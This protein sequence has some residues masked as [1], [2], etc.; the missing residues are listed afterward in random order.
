[1]QDS[2]DNG[3]AGDQVIALDST[4]DSLIFR[5]PSSGGT[6]GT[7]YILTLDQLATDGTG[8]LNIQSAGTGNLLT[9][10]DTTATA[11]DV[12]VVQDGGAVILENQTDSTGA[13]RVRDALGQTQFR[14]D[15]TNASYS[16]VYIGGA[17]GK[18]G[19]RLG[20]Y[21]NGGTSTHAIIASDTGLGGTDGF[22]IYDDVANKH[23]FSLDS[24][25]AVTSRNH[26]DS[27]IAF[28]I[29]NAAGYNY[30]SVDTSNTTHA[31]VN[32]GGNVG[33]PSNSQ[34]NF[35]RAASEG[36]SIIASDNS[37]GGTGGFGIFDDV[38]NAYVLSFSA[39]GSAYFRNQTDSTDA[40]SVQNAAGDDILN[41]DTEHGVITVAASIVPNNS[42]A[43]TPTSLVS[44]ARDTTDNVGQHTAITIGSD[45][46]PVVSYYNVTNTS[47]KV[48]KCGVED[49]SSGNVINEVDNTA[50]VG[51]DTSIAIG[52][53]GFPV[54][55][56][57]DETNGNLRVAK[58]GDVSCTPALVSLN[59]A[60]TGTDLGRESSIAIGTDG[61]PIISH[62]DDN[63]NDLRVTKCDDVACTPAGNTSTA[64]ETSD[65]TGY[66]SSLT[67]GS[68]GL[69]VVAYHN[70]TGGVSLKV[71]KC[72]NTSCTS[73]NT[74][75]EVDVVGGSTL[76]KGA[77]IAIASDGFPV[78]AHQDA[79]ADDM[80]VVKCTNAT[81]TTFNT[82]QIVNSTNAQDPKLVIGT[83]GLPVIA[84]H[85]N[86]SSDLIVTKCGN[87]N[88]TSGNSTTTV[89]TTNDVGQNPSIVI[90]ANGLPVIA[91]YDATAD[92]LR[93]TRCG[94]VSCSG[95]GN[96]VTGG[97]NLGSIPVA[98]ENAYINDISSSNV[99][100]GLTLS[101]NGIERIA[102]G[103][104]GTGTFNLNQ[105]TFNGDILIG[106]KPDFEVP[107]Y[108]VSD[109][110]AGTIDSGGTS[111]IDGIDSMIEYNGSL[112]VGTNEPN[113][114]EIYRYDGNNDWTRVSFAAG[115]VDSGG[116]TSIDRIASMG[117]VNGEL[118]IGTQENNAAEVYRYE[119]GTNWSRMNSAAGDINGG[120]TG[121]DAIRSM[122]G[123]GGL[124]YIGT[125]DGNQAEV[126]SF[127]TGANA[128]AA[129]WTQVSHST[130]G[131]IINGLTSGIDIIPILTVH[132]GKLI[133]GTGETNLSEVYEFNGSTWARISSTTAGTIDTGYTS[134]I[135]GIYGL[136]SYNGSLYAS[137][138]HTSGDGEIYRYNGTIGDWSNVSSSVAGT[139]TASGGSNLDGILDLVMYNGYLYANSFDPAGNNAYLYRYNDAESN[140]DRVNGTAGTL[141]TGGTTGI[142]RMRSMTVSNGVLYF[143]TGEETLAE[144]YAYEYGKSQSYSLKFNAASDKAN[145]EQNGFL[146]DGQISFV[147]EQTG[148]STATG[149]T[150]SF[151]FTHGILTSTGA[152]DVAEDYPTRDHTITPGSLVSI[153]PNEVGFVAKT[154]KEYDS[155]ILGVYSSEPALRL[156]Q[157]T[158]KIDGAKAIPIALAGRV[159]VKV[160][161]ENGVIQPGDYLT[162]SSKPGVAMKATKAGPTVGKAL[163]GF[164]GEGTGQVMTFINISYYEPTIED[165]LQGDNNSIS[166]LTVQG[167]ATVEGTLNVNN[168]TTNNLTVAENAS[169]LG[170]VTIAQNLEVQG[171]IT[172]AGRIITS[173]DVPTT[174]ILPAAGLTSTVEIEGND[175]SGTITLTTSSTEIITSGEL[176]KVLFVDEYSKAPRVVITPVGAEASSL[177]FFVD[178]KQDSFVLGSSTDPEQGKTYRFNYFIVE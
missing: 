41:I 52:T 107:I 5:N 91:H 50:S 114:A 45:G 178:Q 20:F 143:A 68:D 121:I 24:N 130:A 115:Q 77:S 150:G 97:Y 37:V 90:G 163:E 156:S 124:L 128:G 49:C 96:T 176:A 12:L 125:Q 117:V 103:N 148:S 27:A 10:R 21:Q 78:I 149:S 135:D 170:N 60:E 19:S 64:F 108:K 30:L 104:D 89:E 36:W 137:T 112:Y 35:N 92:D 25:G 2:Y 82:P 110:T 171:D 55:S 66:H 17:A 136:T 177:R 138:Y 100:Q 34:I 147:A 29:Q 123:Y 38:N 81:C 132:N 57:Y 61:F 129:G 39:E 146:N 142:D 85:S 3:S 86:S 9:V 73:S 80:V 54:I 153:D 141:E 126:Y 7:G 155:T 161:T 74:I 120:N 32:L 13:F 8:G 93:I 168:L 165:M 139:V 58:C 79:N 173:G 151:L 16:S 83:D 31:T 164:S 157:E 33:G 175:S 152:Y 172:I 144:V 48:L 75:T 28:R 95:S 118:Y 56:Y 113:S 145:D 47:L 159:P 4:N 154:N 14:V 160:S 169:F 65:D 76:G 102:L 131:T 59:D 99:A 71:L 69:P 101:T 11:S 43:E 98:F 70:R 166:S 174:E 40:F 72:G 67:I 122:V 42:S 53:D 6:N 140:W 134:G 1:M 88:C 15:N 158:D 109:S 87:I 105:S 84:Y 63:A 23:V 46:L 111:S 162:S 94:N 116:T 106:A 44:D 119:G 18:V 133:A 51:R 167:D 62:F 26:T 22:S 127:E